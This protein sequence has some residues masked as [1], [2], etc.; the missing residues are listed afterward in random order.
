MI[1]MNIK[2]SQLVTKGYLPNGI[3]VYMVEFSDEIKYGIIKDH[4]LHVRL[5]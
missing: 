4:G 1:Y 5:V 3:P 2:R